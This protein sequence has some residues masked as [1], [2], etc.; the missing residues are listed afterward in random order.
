MLDT[1]SRVVTNALLIAAATGCAGSGA[2]QVADSGWAPTVDSGALVNDA[3]GRLEAGSNDGGTTGDAGDLSDAGTPLLEAGGSVAGSSDGSGDEPPPLTFACSPVAD[4][5]G[6]VSVNGAAARQFYVDLPNDPSQ[7][8][9]LL[10]SWHGYNQAPVDFKN[11]VGFDPNG[12]SMPIVVVTPTDT[13]LFLQQIPSGGLDWD[14]QGSASN[15]DFPYFQGMLACLEGQFPTIDA[16]RVYSFGFSAGAVFTNLLT[17]QWPHVFAATVSESGA[18][19]SDPAERAATDGVGL[20]YPWDWPALDPA[21]RG[22]VL[23]THGGT[24][25]YATIISIELADQAALP[26]L[27]QAKRTVVDCA[28]TAGHAIDPLV[29]NQAI[30]EYLLAHQLGQPSPF[31][32]GAGLFPGFPPSCALHVP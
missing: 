29:N 17:S 26:F 10:F 28:H 20:L 11:A 25:D 12:G 23:M 5:V 7:P 8:M 9:A 32:G 27:L 21:D 31:Q 16:T 4:G 2:A 14:I 24:T 18:W 22:E 19:F 1:A 30:Y 15:V 6:A 3:S 13:G